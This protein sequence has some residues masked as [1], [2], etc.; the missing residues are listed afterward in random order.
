MQNDGR[1]EGLERLT[2]KSFSVRNQH[3]I[4]TSFIIA[5]IKDAISKYAKGEMLDI[6]CGNKPYLQLFN[7]HIDK[8]T[9][10]DIIQSSEKVVDFLC[11]ANQLCFSDS[12]F[13][14]IFSTQTMEHVADHQGMVSETYR[15]LKKG[16]FAI[17]TVPFNW[18]LHEEPYDFFRFTKY[19]LK[20]LFEKKGFEVMYVKSNGGK[21]ASIF[22]LWLN[23]LFS[24]RKYVTVRSRFIKFLLLDLKLIVPYN[25]FSVWLDKQF[26]DDVLTL[27]YIIVAKKI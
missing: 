1:E 5:D 19:G 12:C 18:E 3:Y 25:K 21:W 27:N 2:Y 14:T 16:G 26:F 20:N 13:D 7:G 15:V 10:C 22:Q 6:G 23:V 4:V 24:T 9:G 17:F 11:P 8:Y